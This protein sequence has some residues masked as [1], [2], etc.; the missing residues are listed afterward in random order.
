MP[1]THE[2]S[3]GVDGEKAGTARD[4]ESQE[5]NL[6]IEVSDLR[7]PPHERVSFVPWRRQSVQVPR[8]V[9]DVA[10]AGILISLL[11]VATPIGS[12][13][14]AFAAH[15]TPASTAGRVVSLAAKSAQLTPVPYPTPT[16]NVPAVG[17]VSANCLPET[18]PVDFSSSETV[19]G[20]GGSGVWFIASDRSG[21]R[22]DVELPPGNYTLAGW[23]V[24]VMVYI[25]H[26]FTQPI[27]LM[28]HDLLT[29]YSLWLSPDAT[30]PGSLADAAPLAT[31]NPGQGLAHTSDAQWD[32]W[33]GVLYLPGAGCY[34]VQANWPGNGWTIDFAA[35]R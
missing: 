27:T 33:S 1:G 23:P 21:K 26:G 14:V 28:G 20:V 31:I 13:L 6:F 22:G 30:S 5:D 3:S 25:K 7:R 4:Q 32:I 24:P 15:P 16:L 11:L 29:G 9:V 12:A 8:P 19:P 17:P 34:I 35:G 18:P 2:P 10:L